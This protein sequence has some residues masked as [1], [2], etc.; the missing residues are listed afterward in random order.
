RELRDR[1][2]G[3]TR[4]VRVG[5]PVADHQRETVAAVLRGRAAR[6]VAERGEA[7]AARLAVAPL[8][9]AEAVQVVGA[10]LPPRA[11]LALVRADRR[12]AMVVRARDDHLRLI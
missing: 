10:D 12:L 5:P 3:E 7:R 1:R 8:G 11:Q 9:A 6:V 4:I 2:R